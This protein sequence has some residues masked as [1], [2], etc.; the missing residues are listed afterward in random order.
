MVMPATTIC[1]PWKRKI[2]RNR[3][4]NN[5]IA[6]QLAE[7]QAREAAASSSIINNVLMHMAEPDDDDKDRQ[8]A[9]H[10]LDP[11]VKYNNLNRTNSGRNPF[12]DDDESDYDGNGNLNQLQRES[13][14]DRILWEE[15]QW[16]E[17]LPAMYIQ[18]IKCSRKTFQWGHPQLWNQDWKEPCWCSGT[19]LRPP[20]KIVV[21]DIMCTFV[22]RYLMNR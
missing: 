1:M 14:Q 19:R 13:Y 10:G 15:E 6:R 5:D 11:Q 22:F 17:V 9:P 12:S 3:R 8:G 20:K 4:P 18:F 21:F 16:R 2:K 7:L